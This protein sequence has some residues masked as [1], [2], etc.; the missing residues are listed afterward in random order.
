MKNINL[1][2]TY[3]PWGTDSTIWW[4]GVRNDSQIHVPK[5]QDSGPNS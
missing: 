2:S 4:N 5:S 1:L 3:S